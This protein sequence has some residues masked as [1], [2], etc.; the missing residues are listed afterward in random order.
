MKHAFMIL[1]HKDLKQIEAL[2]SG[3]AFGDIYIHVDKKNDQLFNQLKLFYQNHTNI[4]ILEERTNVNWSG[5]SMVKATLTLIKYI[6]SANRYYDY[7]HLISGQDM[8]LMNHKQLD[9][10]LLAKGESKIFIEY[11]DIGSYR[12]RVKRYSLFRENPKNRT[13]LLRIL[14]NLIRYVQFIIPERNNLNQLQ[15][16]KGS[17]WYTIS[18]ECLIYINKT[19]NKYI[20]DF[21]KT[22]CADEHFFQ[23]LIMNS[24][25]KN[26]V[27]N[28]NLRYIVFKNNKSSPEFI[29]DRDFEKMMNGNY[30]FARKF[31]STVNQNIVDK[32]KIRLFKL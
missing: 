29:S 24:E 8:I 3:L 9:D 21:Y 32:I 4:F 6:V 14:D 23:I 10:F 25:Y 26:K 31:E 7:I 30:I 2:I 28:D 12:W 20:K 5:F 19:A 1:A 13:I 27:V 11:S 16:Y 17:Q 22:A 18:Y 15:L